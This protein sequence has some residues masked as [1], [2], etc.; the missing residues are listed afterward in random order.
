[1]HPLV[2]ALFTFVC[3]TVPQ[4][5]FA[6]GQ[7]TIDRLPTSLMYFGLSALVLLLIG[8]VEIL[9]VQRTSRGILKRL[10]LGMVTFVALLAGVVIAVSQS[11]RSS[12]FDAVDV[13]FE[14]PDYTLYIVGGMVVGILVGAISA[15]VRKDVNL[16]TRLCT[17]ALTC[18][19]LMFATYVI[20]PSP[21]RIET[22][23]TA[24]KDV[25]F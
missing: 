11:H 15:I 7:V 18:G 19:A 23:V 13:R 2:F 21:T 3:T 20:S 22:P 8:G 12:S 16:R 25:T 17:F 9:Y 5:A 1:M 24:V 14:I 4:L 6:C 10:A